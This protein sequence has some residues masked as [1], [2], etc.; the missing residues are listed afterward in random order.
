MSISLRAVLIVVS[1]VT[2]WRI[3]RK[4]RASKLRIEDS[5]FWIGFSSLL[6][7]FSVFPQVAYR[8]SWLVGT[9][10][11]VNFIY[12]LVIFLLILR[13]FSMTL[14]MSQ[15]ETKI[16]EL[17]QRI[18]IDENIEREKGQDGENE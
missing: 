8:L 6:I 14:K 18:A 11:P 4:V 12:L 10:T 17:V 3:V 16:W 7:V 15:M 9:Q 1:V 2:T 5:M 13:L